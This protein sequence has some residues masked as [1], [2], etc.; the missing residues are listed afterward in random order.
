MCVCA[1]VP[2]IKDMLLSVPPLCISPSPPSDWDTRN[3]GT[4]GHRVTGTPGHW[5][6]R[7]L[8]HLDTGTPGH[9]NTGTPG[10]WDS[11]A[12]GHWDSMWGAR[13]SAHIP[14]PCC[15]FSAYC[16]T[17][18][19]C[20]LYNYQNFNYN[21]TRHSGFD[22]I[23]ALKPPSILTPPHILRSHYQESHR[24]QKNTSNNNNNN[25]T[26]TTNNNKNYNTK[27]NYNKTTREKIMTINSTEQNNRDCTCT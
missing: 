14:K 17:Q 19:L 18:M 20:Y 1:H 10:H 13:S 5:D 23:T 25:N 15:D 8:G 24:L 11:G 6:I 21:T 22:M 7:T 9:W 16:C 26:T 4:P 27:D 2:V 12:M 3:T